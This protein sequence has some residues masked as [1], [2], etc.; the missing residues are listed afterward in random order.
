MKTRILLL[1]ATALP[2]FAADALKVK[3]GMWETTTEISMA[4]LTLPESVTSN[5]TPEQRARMEEMMKQ[6]AAQGPRTSTVKS[7]VTAEDI[8]QG[9]F[10]A[11]NAAQQQGCKYE[12]VSSTPQRQEMT[13]SCGG[14]M[15][16]TGRMVLN[17]IDSGNVQGDMQMKMQQPGG[18][19]MKFKSRWLGAN[20]TEAAK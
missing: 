7:C 18:I 6:M 10:R 1:L 5:M 11:A 13:M 15:N 8:K 12:V 16:A 19:S 9:N 3:P 2:V 17:V 4:G 14:Q 20:C